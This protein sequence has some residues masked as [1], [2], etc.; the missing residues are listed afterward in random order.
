MPSYVLLLKPGFDGAHVD[1]MLDVTKAVVGGTFKD[2]LTTARVIDRIDGTNVALN[3]YKGLLHQVAMIELRGRLDGACDGPF[4]LHVEEPLTYDEL[5]HIVNT[6][7]A[8][9]KHLQEKGRLRL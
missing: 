2:Y 1:S 8:F 6:S 5:E 7:A 4:L 3:E 9:V